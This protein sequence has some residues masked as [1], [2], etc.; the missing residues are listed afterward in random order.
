MDDRTKFGLGLLGAALLLGLLGDL[1]LRATPW[2]INV[3]LW[4]GCLASAAVALTHRGRL[5]VEGGGRWLVPVAVFF[6][7]AVAWRDSPV[8]ASLDVLAVLIALSLAAYRGRRG[9]MRLSGISE[10]VLGGIYTGVL[11]SAGPLPVMVNEVRWREVARGRWRGPALAATRGVF[12]AVPLL[13]VFGGLLAAADA[14]FETLVVELFGFDV[15]EALGH[16]L[17]TL[18]F[19]WISAGLLW[20]A[21][22]ASDPHSLGLPRPAALSLG[23]VEVGVVLGL[24]DTLFLAFVAVQVRYLFGGAG[25]VLETAGLTYAEY[26]RRGF[27]ELVSVT[28][29][30]L[31]MLLLAHWLLRAENRAHAHLFR[32]L[33]GAMV[34]LLFVIVA[35]AFQRMYLYTQEFGLTELRL[36]TT[37][38]MSW[39]SVVL[40]WFVPTVLWG[41]RNRF[42]LG[43]LATGFATIFLINALNPD[44]LVARVNVDRMEAGE[45]FDAYYLTLLSADAAPVLFESLPRM[46]E[47]D[48]QTVE[49]AL[50]ARWANAGGTDWRTWNLSRSQARRLAETYLPTSARVGEGGT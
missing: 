29:L 20:V 27:F 8:V 4:V 50:R 32:A 13:L 45:R 42:A 30:V 25:K 22:L 19:A 11:S 48:R 2:G 26:A 38:F 21:L 14:V 9:A 23:I 3:L 16:L 10:Y 6:A 7:A 33:S 43:V 37:I 40:I 31:P 1:L 46:S 44:A 47:Q 24:L 5:D 12:L 34:A 18:F 39:V 41:R 28:A 17:L 36:Y 15:A 49:D 35:S